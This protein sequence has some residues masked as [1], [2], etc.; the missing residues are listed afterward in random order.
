[1]RWFVDITPI[2]GGSTEK[3]CLEAG[4]WQ[5]A[6][7]NA[8][9]KKGHDAPVGELSVEVLDDGFRAVDKTAKVKY[10]VRKAPEDA[11]LTERKRSSC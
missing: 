2:G 7:K 9:D 10:L 5:A 6:L 3:L 1:M 8:R 11:P 4:E